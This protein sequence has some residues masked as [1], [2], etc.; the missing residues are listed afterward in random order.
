[1]G[2]GDISTGLMTGLQ[3]GRLRN[4]GLITGGE[5]EF[6]LL[7]SVQTE[8]GPIRAPMQWVPGPLSPEINYLGHE[9][10]HPPTS[11]AENKDVWIYTF[12]ALMPS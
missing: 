11:S 6:S 4:R 2:A 8:S 5:K 1:M 12:T 10:D 7:R 9:A 3:M